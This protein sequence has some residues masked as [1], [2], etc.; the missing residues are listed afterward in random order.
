LPAGALAAAG[1]IAGLM[2]YRILAPAPVNYA[3]LTR[4]EAFIESNWNNTVG[5]S[6]NEDITVMLN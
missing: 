5:D 3:E 1:L 4:L 6:Q 2:N